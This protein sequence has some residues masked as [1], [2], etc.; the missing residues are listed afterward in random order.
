MDVSLET[1]RILSDGELSRDLPQDTLKILR[2]GSNDQY[3]ATLSAIALDA[4]F[5]LRIFVRVKR[6]FVEICSRWLEASPSETDSVSVLVALAGILPF[7][8]H[9]SIYVQETIMRC[10]AGPL[11]ALKSSDPTLLGNLHQDVL[12]SILLALCRLLHHDNERFAVLIKPSQFQTLLNHPERAVRYL[13]IKILCMYLHA[14]DAAFTQMRERYLDSGAIEGQWEHRNIDYAFFSLWEQKRARDIRMAL[15]DIENHDMS[16]YH[17]SPPQRFIGQGEFSQTT[18]C[19]AGVLIPSIPTLSPSDRSFIV[20]T[21][22]V[23]DN[24]RS[25]AEGIIEHKPLLVTGSSGAGKTLLIKE[26]ARSLGRSS[27]MVT[28]HLNEQTDAKLLIGLYSSAE[29]PGSFNWQPGVLTKAVMEGRWVLIEDLDRAPPEIMS[30][31]LPLL[32]R[33]ELLVQNRGTA[34]RA[35]PE[36]RLIATIRSSNAIGGNQKV[37]ESSTIGAR[38]WLHVPLSV[39]AVKELTEIA[40]SKFP[41]LQAYM[42]RIISLYTSLVGRQ[43]RNSIITLPKPIAQGKAYGPRDLLK[44]CARMNS[45]LV[46][47]GIESSHEPISEA[48]SDNLFLEAVDC[49]A[50]ALPWGHPREMTVTAISQN[51][52]MPI[53]RAKYCL[54]RKP[55]YVIND[56]SIK[57]GRVILQRKRSYATSMSSATR[58]RS[59]KFTTTS[60]VLRNLECVSTAVKM[61]EPCL[62]IG[63]T[64]TG[65]TAIVQHLA[66]CLG[67]KLVVVNLSQQS[68]GS[69]LLGGFKPVN[70]RTLAAPMSDEFDQLFAETK[71]FSERNQIYLDH[72]RKAVVKGRWSQALELWHRAIRKADKSFLSDAG[73]QIGQI[74]SLPTKR[75]KLDS[76]KYHGLRQ[77]WEKFRAQVQL[78]QKHLESGSKGFAFSFI[79]GNIVKAARDGDWVLLDEI[80]LASSDTLESLADLITN[81]AGESPSL[82][83]SETG[84]AERVHAHKDFR[85]FGAM[86]PATDIG[87]RDLPAGLRSRFTEVFVESPDRDYDDLVALTKA[88]LG[89]Y[90]QVDARAAADAAKLY[91]EIQQL[92]ADSRLVDGANQKPHFSLRTLTR[93]IRFVVDVAPIYGLRRALYEGFSMSFLTV[94]NKTSAMTLATLI[95]K[96][97]LDLHKNSKAILFQMPKVPQDSK[98]YVR[99]RHYLMQKG[100]FPVQEQA[101]YIITPF[102][103]RN[104]LNLVRATSTRKFPVLLQGPTSSGK[105]SMVEHLAKISG[106]NFVRINNHEHTDLQEYF[107]TYV[108]GPDGRLQYQEGVLVQALREGHWIVLDELN[109]APTDVLEALNRLLDDNRELLIPETQQVIY[110]HENFMLFATQNPPGMYGGRKILSRAF[111]NRFLELHF[112]DIPENELETILQE[113][114]QTARHPI[115]PSFCAKIVAVYKRLSVLRQSQRLFEQKNSFATLRDLFRW[116]FRGADTRE[117]LAIDGFLILAER[118]RNHAER[119][120]VKQAIEDIVKVHID[121]ND[122]YSIKRLQASAGFSSQIS[123][124]LVWTRSVR[125]LFVLVHEALNNNEPILLVGDTGSG[126]TSICQVVSQVL[127]KE[128]HIVN[129]YQNMETSD[130]IGSQRPLRDRA[131]VEQQLQKHLHHVLK[132]FADNQTGDQASLE[133]L[134]QKFDEIQ[135]VFGEKLPTEITQTIQEL[136]KRSKVLFEW[137]DGS[138][139]RAM[140]AGQHFLLDEISLADDSVLER[141]NSVLEPGRSLFLA[142]KGTNDA[143]V[144]AADG[145]Q[146]FATMNPGG[147]YGKKELSPALRNRFT[148]I[149]A[150]HVSVKEEIVEILEEKL[151]SHYAKFAKPMV[152]FAAW[153]GDTYGPTRPSISIRDLLSWTDFINANPAPNNLL[154]VF[155]GCALTYIDSLGTKPTAESSIS[156]LT[157]VEQ[158]RHCLEKMSDLFA[159]DMS[160]LYLNELSLSSDNDRLR[161]GNF[162]LRKNASAASNAISNNPYNLEAPTTLQ[163]MLK[164]MR[165]LQLKKP[166]LLEG[167]PGVG[168]TTLITALAEAIHMPLTRMNLSDQTD[169]MDL[170]GS[171]IPLEDAEVGSFRWQDAPFLEAMQKGEWVL[172]DEMNLAPQAVLEGLNACFDH[173]GEVYISELD[174]TFTRHP[175]FAVFAT[176]NPHV[177]GGGRKGLPRSFVNRFSVLYADTYTADD[178]LTICSQ[179]FH[180]MPTEK[181]KTLISTVV[182]LTSR[183]HNDRRSGLRGGSW[184]FNLRDIMRWL[185]LLTSPH[186]LLPAGDV[187]HYS[188]ILFLQRLRAAQEIDAASTILRHH[189]PQSV[190]HNG[191]F[192]TLSI[193]H[194]Q[195]GLGIIS[196]NQ[197]IQPLTHRL[198]RLPSS[199]FPVAESVMLCIQNNWP[200]LLVGASGSGKTNL[201]NYLAT[202]AGR[203][204]VN[205]PLNI[206]MDTM[207]LLGGYEQLDAHRKVSSLL[208]RVKDLCRSVTVQCLMSKNVQ[209]QLLRSLEEIV[210][211]RIADPAQLSAVLRA[212]GTYE[213]SS[214]FDDLAKECDEILAVSRKDSRARFEW[215]DGLFVQ[216]LREGKWLILDNANLCNLSV[217]D[218][219]NSVLEPN[220]VLTINERRS[221]DGSPQVLKP[222]PNFRLFLTMDPRHGELSRAMRNRCVELFI[223]TRQLGTPNA[224]SLGFES[225]ISR[226]R[227]F[228]V[229]NHNTSNKAVFLELSAIFVDHLAISD[230]KLF[231]RWYSQ[232]SQGMVELPPA[233][234]AQFL[235]IFE[236]YEAICSSQNFVSNGIIKTYNHLIRGLR[237]PENFSEAQVSRLDVRGKNYALTSLVTRQFIRSKI[238]HLYPLVLTSTRLSTLKLSARYLKPWL[239][240]RILRDN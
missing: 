179:S 177:Q 199:H 85:I 117:Q 165:A 88:Y 223:P 1:L 218:R 40:L 80:N 124:D 97:F 138:L 210:L 114:S 192:S 48:L 157:V 72:S 209:P 121:E 217:L 235:S 142:E 30:I 188:Q 214:G 176:Q 164:I 47:A 73:H 86:N 159:C 41:I 77:R 140:K 139:V 147:D 122:L 60:L 133:S 197:L 110:P 69:D 156:T 68:E 111:R 240:S 226:F 208:S 220:G 83:I 5:T 107:G 102:I 120:V 53:E 43:S 225:L 237:V 17:G 63:E 131:S 127:R 135:V 174:R 190:V 91:L 64:G 58:A 8:P 75:R 215:V 45:L 136:R 29:S 115:P 87:K 51:L 95:Q 78:F 49:F 57:I 143:L 150:P 154:P 207:D 11:A 126:K 34:I 106:N 98:V 101:H 141:L 155:H 4:H 103:E 81:D 129:A 187:A 128:L 24:L 189:L 31:L 178:L 84:Q 162:T 152:A 137:A 144:S 28:L 149:W 38:H 118:V 109:L 94:L 239:G 65:K 191:F 13:S 15:R 233:R 146:F 27:S 172:L 221:P 12:C 183:L 151:V 36:F 10:P 74:N 90:S 161:I 32:E 70:L 194:L 9:L 54:N 180:N 104:L 203:S 184:E 25:V 228:E 134:L 23:G 130:L 71:L 44:C 173:R 175:N 169:L 123:Q 160:S 145:F 105:T 148:E 202:C 37:L 200:C 113:R 227:Y 89:N 18:V 170:F 230:I 125:R 66:N 76:A 198:C 181:T 61:A 163:N 20:E 201:I 236:V 82:L 39:P 56:G 6:I 2:D 168:K 224:L 196:R 193:Q 212:A 22:T 232:V 3:L 211:G 205:L 167:N 16:G 59:S 216:A 234:L 52:H 96:Y 222:H 171:D 55:Q 132:D 229:L 19:V 213:L 92:V 67:R 99:F 195:I 186:G 50:G 112:D 7:A 182:D 79:E 62:L 93:T 219:L 108:S 185:R 42:P 46:C 33:H 26:V 119:A 153:F 14:S 100:A 206:A 158:R 21:K 166:I 231:W 204:V 35:A 116:A 238:L